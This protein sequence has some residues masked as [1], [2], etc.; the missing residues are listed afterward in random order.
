MDEWME[1][2]S[3]NKSSLQERK[4][5]KSSTEWNDYTSGSNKGPWHRNPLTTHKLLETTRVVHFPISPI[6]SYHRQ[7]L[8]R[9]HP[10]KINHGRYVRVRHALF[11][12]RVG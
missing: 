9:H 11:K 2:H 8:W 3:V 6:L 4:K 12:T 1:M 7:N 10:E 5:T